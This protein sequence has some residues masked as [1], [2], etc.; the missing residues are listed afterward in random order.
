MKAERHT[1]LNTILGTLD[2]SFALSDEEL[3]HSTI[4]VKRMLERLCIPER[5]DPDMLPSSL[6][7]EAEAGVFSAQLNGPRNAGVQRVVRGVTESDTVVTL[8][9]WRQALLSLI[10]TAYP[11]LEPTERLFVVQTIDELLL[12]LG[13]PERAASFIP[14]TVVRAHLSGA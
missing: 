7:L 1:W 12:A 14:D 10:T 4:I 3:Y 13:V 2:A 6:A 8:E 5:G 11:D 9:A